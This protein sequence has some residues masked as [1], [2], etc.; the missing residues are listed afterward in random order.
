MDNGSLTSHTEI[1]LG[2]AGY[3]TWPQLGGTQPVI[4]FEDNTIAGFIHV[5]AD[6]DALIAGWETA[7]NSALARNAAALRGAGDKAWNIYSVLLTTAPA[8]KEQAAVLDA[9]EE[10]FEATRKIACAGI[11][12]ALDVAAALQPLLPIQSQSH[13]GG[14]D[15]EARLR[16]GLSDLPPGAVTA[17]IGSASTAELLQIVAEASR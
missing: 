7:Q 13:V 11:T 10:N 15:Y 3:A 14:T 4:C 1:L 9:I 6:P 16:T 2:N 17:L 5:F 8:S 12:T